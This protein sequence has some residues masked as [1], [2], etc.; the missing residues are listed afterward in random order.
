M[1]NSGATHHVLFVEI[2]L[3][4]YKDVTKTVYTPL[5]QHDLKDK[6]LNTG[7]NRIFYDPG[8][9]VQCL[10][11][12]SDFQPVKQN[13]SNGSEYAWGGGVKNLV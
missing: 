5:L 7:Y 10:S 1:P 2:L 9:N 4:I 13:I 11:F 8:S 3:I 12:Y 6:C